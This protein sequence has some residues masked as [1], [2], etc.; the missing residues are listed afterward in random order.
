MRPLLALAAIGAL[1]LGAAPAPSGHETY[2]ALRE[3]RPDGRVVPIQDVTI[4]RDVFRIRLGPGTLHLLAPVEDRTLGAV[5]LGSGEYA[6]T[7]ATE[8]ERRHLALRA[9]AP[10][11][12]ELT[13]TFNS[14]VLLFSDGTADELLAASP[15]R[16]EAPAEEALRAYETYL[17]WQR[18]ELQSNVH[19]SLVEDLANEG[20][21]TGGAFYAF[22]HGK[23][24]AHAMIAVD[25]MGVVDATEGGRR[26]RAVRGPGPR[27][28][29]LAP[30][31]CRSAAR[32]N[33]NL[34]KP[35]IGPQHPPL[36]RRPR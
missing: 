14:L 3:A 36:R 25:P 28:A 22:P 10:T 24:F 7:P 23:Q 8:A 19:L 5:Y 6:L 4:E 15:P 11:L 32:A 12:R 34:R 31:G 30:P 18:K 33:Y 17:K 26:Q 2:R 13:D 21:Q 9:G 29:A 1:G 27:P 16:A 20:S 35:W